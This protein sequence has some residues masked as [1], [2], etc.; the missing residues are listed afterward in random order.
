M[1]AEPV[2][3]EPAECRTCRRRMSERTGTGQWFPVGQPGLAAAGEHEHVPVRSAWVAQWR[4]LYAADPVEGLLALVDEY[5]VE[6]AFE[7]TVAGEAAGNTAADVAAA[8][9]RA[10]RAHLA[11][12]LGDPR[13]LHQLADQ[14]HAAAQ[15]VT[16]LE[17]DAAGQ[18]GWACVMRDREATGYETAQ[19]A[20][21]AA[22]K[23]GPVY[24]G[25]LFAVYPPIVN[26]GV[27]GRRGAGGA[28]YWA[29][30]GGWLLVGYGHADET[31]LDQV[32][33]AGAKAW[34]AQVIDENLAET[35]SPVGSMM[36]YRWEEHRDALGSWWAPVL[37]ERCETCLANRF[38][39]SDHTP[40]YQVPPRAYA[41]AG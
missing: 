14:V 38:A 2:S 1:P 3:G 25:S 32:D 21:D 40:P 16:E 11:G 23:H 28:L 12:I 31:E 26:Y 35:G 36:V 5:G 4:E 18:W 33:V 13:A 27:D 7:T 41:M 9:A 30:D 24:A 22:E 37:V 34:A 6:R 15:H 19:E 10:V 29:R 39:C 17:Q 20:Q 8:R